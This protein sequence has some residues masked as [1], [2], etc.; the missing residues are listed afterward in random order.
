[1]KLVVIVNGKGGVGK[2]TLCEYFCKF[3]DGEIASAITPIKKMAKR[4]GWK[5]GKSLED[6]LFLSSLKDLLDKRFDTSWTYLANRLHYFDNDAKKVM[7]IMMREPADIERFTKYAKGQGFNVK[8][9]LVRRDGISDTSYGN[10]ADD[11]VEDFQYDYIFENNAPLEESHRD[12][13][14]MIR[15]MTEEE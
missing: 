6:R 5:G 7:F 3:Y 10:H 11:D 2:D 13:I 14:I 8:T 4:I 12:F 15:H 1:M 9:L